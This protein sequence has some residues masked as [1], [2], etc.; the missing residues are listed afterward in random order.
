M[1]FFSVSKG[2]EKKSPNE[3]NNSRKKSVEY[4]RICSGFRVEYGISALA[5]KFKLLWFEC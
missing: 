1:M 3:E 4:E 2:K 5:G